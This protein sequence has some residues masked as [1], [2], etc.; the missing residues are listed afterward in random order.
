M[1]GDTPTSPGTGL[2]PIAQPEFIGT[3]GMREP[4]KYMWGATS[5]G[6]IWPPPRLLQRIGQTCGWLRK[7]HRELAAPE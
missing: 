2:P 7:S 6:R 3:I 4:Y 5:A 1:V